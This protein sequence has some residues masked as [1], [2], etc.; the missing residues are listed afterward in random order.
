MIRTAKQRYYS[1]DHIEKNVMGGARRMYGE[2][3]GL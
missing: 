2:N 3:R 1:G